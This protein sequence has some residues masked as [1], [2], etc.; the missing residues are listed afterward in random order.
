M[1]SNVFDLSPFYSFL[2]KIRKSLRSHTRPRFKKFSLNLSIHD[3]NVSCGPVSFCV[4]HSSHFV[5][6]PPS[7]LPTVLLS[8]VWSRLLC[9]LLSPA[10]PKATS[11]TLGTPTHASLVCFAFCGPVTSFCPFSLCQVIYECSVNL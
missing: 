7:T 1:L 6:P 5:S 8:P 2:S 4:F 10:H 9:Q 3:Q 11:S